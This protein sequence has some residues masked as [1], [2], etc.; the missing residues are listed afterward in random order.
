[1]A[2]EGVIDF[3]RVWEVTGCH[4]KC[5]WESGIKDGKGMVGFA[6]GLL[7]HSWGS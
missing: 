5:F 4:G 7:P 3:Y 2:A 1:M 6:I